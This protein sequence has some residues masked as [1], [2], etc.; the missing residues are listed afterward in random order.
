ME[1]DKKIVKFFILKLFKIH[2]KSSRL[3]IITDAYPNGK[4]AIISTINSPVKYFFATTSNGSV[5]EFPS[6]LSS[7]VKNLRII[8]KKNISSMKLVIQKIGS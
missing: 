1:S 2:R 4:N 3:S 8:C 5:L 7:W 6:S